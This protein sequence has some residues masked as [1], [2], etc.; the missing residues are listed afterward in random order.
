ESSRREATAG[1]VVRPSWFLVQLTW[2]IV[3]PIMIRMKAELPLGQMSV[4]EKLEAMD[5]LWAD[6]SRQAPD[7]AVP[8]GTPRFWQ[9]GRDAWQQGRKR[10]WIGMRRRY[11]CVEKSMKVRILESA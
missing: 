6:L 8:S 2:E 4:A 7:A 10:S 1:A 5:A 3:W 11:G 9:S